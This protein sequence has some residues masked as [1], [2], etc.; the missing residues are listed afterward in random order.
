MRMVFVIILLLAAGCRSA[1]QPT[2]Q[3]AAQAAQIDLTIDPQPPVVGDAGLTATVTRDGQP[4]T[5]ATVSVRGDMTH[6]GMRPE[7]ASGVTDAQGKA[8]IP[9][10]WTMSGDWIVTVTVT[11]ADKSEVAQEFDV[12]VGS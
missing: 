6:A 1:A 9:F 8:I 11:L 7:L 12:S 10:H 5:E 4:V 3:P 2:P